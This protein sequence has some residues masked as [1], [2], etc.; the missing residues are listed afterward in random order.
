MK[1]LTCEMC[2]STDLI[3]QDGVFVCQTC[4]CKYSIEEAKKMM[5]EGTVDVQG[6]V[7]VD[8]S[9]FVEKYLANARRAKEKEDWEEVEKYYNMVEQNDPDNI[10][11]IFYSAY[12]KAKQTLSDDDIYKRQAAFKVL[13][14]CISVIDDHYQ[15]D[16]REQ[17]KE[18]IKN[19]ADDLGKII[20]SN[21]VYTK[22]KNGYG[23]VIKTNK[24]ETYVLFASLLDAYKETINNIKKIDN[25]PYLYETS[26]KFYKVASSTG[27]GNW[28][29]LMHEWIDVENKELKD[30]KKKTKDAYWAEHAEEKNSLEAEK[31]SLEEQITELNKQIE[32]LPE[33]VTIKDIKEQITAKT[34]EKA[35]L[36]LFKG[37]EKEALQEQID[38]LKK[39]L[40]EAEKAK[41]TAS[42]SYNESIVNFKKR[43]DEINIE[44]TKDR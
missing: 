15:L 32:L 6:T 14:N 30:L 17:N 44:L 35:R 7:K 8:N 29:K 4:G 23:I 25:Q 9:A 22:W 2:G 38:G 43:I 27:I 10:E 20:C 28:T 36:G 34:N 26:I 16:R 21:F 40:T 3:K 5:I 18:A 42:V 39:R 12:G 1:Q 13:K 19:M 37:K 31:N 11:A 41:E 33:V 24:N